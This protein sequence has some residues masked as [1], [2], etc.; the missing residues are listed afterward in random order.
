MTEKLLTEMSYEE[1]EALIDH[2]ID[3]SSQQSEEM[4][5]SA[6]LSLLAETMARRTKQTVEIEG[7]IV[8]GRLELLQPN[9][10]T[11]GLYVQNNQIVIGEQR[12]SVK[13]LA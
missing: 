13:I 2:Y 4:P 1:M 3:R 8:N 6:F 7:R 11:S 12:I 9:T 5:A 10:V